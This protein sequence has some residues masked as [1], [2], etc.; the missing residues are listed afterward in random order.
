MRISE[1]EN[2][3]SCL[4]F[5]YDADVAADLR[6]KI[7]TKMATQ[8]MSPKNRIKVENMLKELE[9]MQHE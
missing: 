4:R 7:L 1:I 9:E 2:T 3:L 8:Q 5:C 6:D